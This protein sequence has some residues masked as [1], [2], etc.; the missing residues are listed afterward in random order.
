MSSSAVTRY[1]GAGVY[2]VTPR[3]P[4]KSYPR[5]APGSPRPAKRSPLC[6]GWGS[7]GLAPF[8]PSRPGRSREQPSA[9]RALPAPPRWSRRGDAPPAWPSAWRCSAPRCERPRRRRPARGPAPLWVSE[10]A[11]RPRGGAGGEGA[12]AARSARGRPREGRPLPAPGV[13]CQPRLPWLRV[14]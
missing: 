3:F 9:G 13:P 10:A 5:L 6:P 4:S 14:P 1:S 2:T 8:L 7:P 11:G 12:A